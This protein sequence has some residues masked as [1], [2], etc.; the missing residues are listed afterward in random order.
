MQWREEQGDDVT[1]DISQDED[2]IQV[3]EIARAIRVWGENNFKSDDET[4]YP[5]NRSS[6][7]HH[8]PLQSSVPTS[9]RFMR[10]FNR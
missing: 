3:E 2:A 10:I 4:T 6:R 1:V 9:F 5:R 8:R 7:R